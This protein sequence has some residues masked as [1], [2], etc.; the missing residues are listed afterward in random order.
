MKKIF[1]LLLL[2]ILAFSAAAQDRRASLAL[3]SKNVTAGKLALDGL[4]YETAAGR[5]FLPAQLTDAQKKNGRIAAEIKMPD[6]RTIKLSVLPE[7]QNFNFNLTADRADDI[8]KWGVQIDA[9]ADEYYT[10]LMERVV[11]GPQGDS[12]KPGITAAMNLRGQKVDMIVKPTTSVYAPFYLSSRGYAVFTRGDWPGFYD[13]A[14]S[15]PNRVKIEFEGPTFE[16][17]IYTSKT[18]SDLIARHSIDAG[19]PILPPKWVFSP[20]R[21]RDVHTQ[22]QAYYDGTPVTGPFNS[23]VME[24]ARLRNSERRLLDRSPVGFRKIFLRRFFDR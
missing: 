4:F 2:V 23:E 24:D 18:P 1:L 17:K 14:A 7:G 3:P 22:R 8:K 12:W 13:F 5:F 16:L 11:D 20:W 10:G 19:A 9:L 6:G 21:W 15:D